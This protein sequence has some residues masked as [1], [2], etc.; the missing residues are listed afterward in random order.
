MRTREHEYPVTL[1]VLSSSKKNHTVMKGLILFAFVVYSLQ[2]QIVFNPNKRVDCG[3]ISTAWVFDKPIPND[4]ALN[5]EALSARIV[6]PV[7]VYC[8]TTQCVD[9]IAKLNNTNI[10]VEFLVRLATL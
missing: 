10:A 9:A 4:L 5:I 3:R 2:I 7:H 8:G 1:T 6:N